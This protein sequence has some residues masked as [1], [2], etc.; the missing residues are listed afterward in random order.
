[1]YKQPGCQTDFVPFL[2]LTA[3]GTSSASAQCLLNTTQ[4]PPSEF[5]LLCGVSRLHKKQTAADLHVV[6]L[7]SA[8]SFA[9]AQVV[10]L[11]V[12]HTFC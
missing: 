7:Q 5:L 3:P 6:W 10:L 1:M 8:W 4:S 2:S 12:A 9:E 11:F